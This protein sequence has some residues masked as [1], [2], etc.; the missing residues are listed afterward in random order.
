MR[1]LIKFVLNR[2]SAHEAGQALIIVLVFLMLGS[3]TLVPTLVHISTSL[4]TGKTYEAHTNELY[5][6]DSGIEDGL[7]RIKYDFM[8]VDYNPYDFDTE[9]DYE[10]DEINGVA[11]NF[12]IKNVWFPSDVTLESLGLTANDAKAM[13]ES[14]KLV[15]AGTSGAIIG[16]PYHV[17]IDFTPDDGDN[18]TVKSLGVW[19]PQGFEYISGNCSLL[20]GSPTEPDHI[21]VDPAPGG[22]TVVWSY[23]EPYPLFAD[24][25]G[26]SDEII[27]MT[28]DFTFGYTPPAEH[29]NWMPLAIAWIT[30]DMDPTCPNLNDVPVSWDTDSRF[31]K[32]VSEAG[33]TEVEA[34]SSKS[35][36]RQMGD[37]MSGD[38]VAIGNS[39]LS[40]DNHDNL[41]ETWHT[42][43]SF[44]LDSIPSDA[45]AAYAYLYWAGWR[46]DSAKSEIFND[47]CNDFNDWN[48]SSDDLSNTSYPS[49]DISH[50]GT[51]DKTTNMYSY[52]DETGSHD[53]DA[54]YLLHGTSS[55]YALFSFPAFSVP[56]GS[57][58]YNLTVSLVARDDSSGS[59]RMQPAL[60]VGGTDYLTESSSTSVPDSYGTINYVYTTN[61]DTGAPWTAEDINGTGSNPLQG[62]GVRSSDADPRIR[63]T[64]VYAQVNYSES[65]W[66]I[67]SGRFHGRGTDSATT[68]QRTLTMKN[69]LN[70]GSYTPTTVVVYWDQY[71]SNN[72][73]DEDAL[74]FAFSGD[75][76]ATWSDDIEAFH[77]DPL[78]GN[79]RHYWYPIPED[80]L[81]SNFKMRFYFN[82]N[83]ANEYVELDDIKVVYMPP[84]TSITFTIDGQQVYFNGSEPAAGPSPL[85]AG[86]SYAMFNS[87]WGVPEGYSYACIRDVTAL[88]KKYP[89]NP[90][91]EHH[92]GNA[93][94]SVDGVTAN[95]GSNFSFAGWSLIVV[96]ASPQTAGHYIYIRDNNFMFHP[97]TGGNIDWDQDGLDG[98]I[99]TNFIVP[100]PITNKYGVITETIAAKLT[101]F[102]VEGDNFGTSS[103]TITGEQSG[104]SMD[105]WNV[106]SPSPD[107]WNGRSYPG[108][109][110]EGV[111]V[112][113]FEVEWDDGILTP[114]DK[115]L[116]VDMYSNNDAWNLV[117][118][119]ISIRSETTTSGTTHYMIRG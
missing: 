115:K 3:L 109:F 96:Y 16:N 23:D 30:T 20:D 37:A 113:T 41:R 110:N 74:Y 11:A 7:W 78:T 50:S 21:N 71:G 44:D 67:D 104:A 17:K 63:L 55:G 117:Y 69:S 70:L 14:E 81:T 29:P 46:N 86:R 22:E 27:P 84:D 5:S 97:G 26:V 52:V 1:Y 19:L 2:L 100:N 111:D 32:I 35:K 4:K 119:I 98:G 68:D 12:T 15:V 83:Q 73:E 49:G 87:M 18:L 94:Y 103:I 40:D 72:L 39:L 43:G 36:L 102:V 88:V 101:C 34:Y 51:W 105:L 99:I 33:I 24:F 106:N 8:G 66:S 114:K 95:T 93:L 116:Y 61:P 107:V 77:N 75:G 42:P 10:T 91:E 65:R 112:D 6:A 31:Y 56:A 45:D 89:E 60:R 54:T 48:R 59:N 47:D 62:F 38:Y 25:P 28:L 118:F 76:G 80:Y 85:I 53:G 82:F 64:Q 58:I 90:G 79:Y 9:W 13:I 92:T 57:N 108:S